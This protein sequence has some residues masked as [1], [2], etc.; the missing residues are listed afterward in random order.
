MI[1]NT[2]RTEDRHEFEYGS[3]FPHRHLILSQVWPFA[4][5]A[6][7]ADNLSGLH[8]LLT[9]MAADKAYPSSAQWCDAVLRDKRGLGP[10][11]SYE[12]S[13]FECPNARTC[14]YAI[15]PACKPD[16]PS[17]VVLLFETKAG[18]NQHG[19]PE[20]FTFDNHDPK[21]GCVLLNDGTVRFIRIGE[22]LKQL[23]WK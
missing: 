16:S 15:N 12:R 23:R 13:L 18:W 19:G 7:C 3:G 6:I 14:H 10:D 1:G 2:V 11:R 17:D 8:G 5:R 20:L 9:Q 22:E 4:L 21:G